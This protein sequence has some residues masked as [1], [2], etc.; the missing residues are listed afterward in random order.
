MWCSRFWAPVSEWR[1][2]K[3]VDRLVAADALPRQGRDGEQ[4]AHVRSAFG[5][6][7]ADS[8]AATDNEP[9][10]QLDVEYG[11]DRRGRVGNQA[12]TAG[13]ARLGRVGGFVFS[14]GNR[15]ARERDAHGVATIRLNGPGAT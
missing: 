3:G 9:P 10:E 4:R 5:V 8:A 7:D 12:G 11:T 2:H 15:Q 14:R 6:S 1:G 13:P